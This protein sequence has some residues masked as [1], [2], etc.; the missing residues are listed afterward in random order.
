[1]ATVLLIGAAVV[2]ALVLAVVAL[3]RRL[4]NCTPTESSVPSD[5]SWKHYRPIERLLDPADFQYLRDRG[6]SEA[7]IAKLRKERRKLYRMCLR[8]L[9]Q[10][11]TKLHNALKLVVVYSRSDRPDLVALLAQ[12]RTT[13]YRNV[14]LVEIRLTLHAFGFERMPQL[15]LLEPLEVLQQQL[16]QLASANMTA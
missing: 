2:L 6:I 9:A 7:K 1:V 15:N 12:Q 11:F 5:L 10:D 4:V 16:Q 13:F 8:S 14:M 3:L